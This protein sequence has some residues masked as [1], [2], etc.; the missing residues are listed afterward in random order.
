M[1]WEGTKDENLRE[2]SYVLDVYAF[3]GKIEFAGLF[4]LYIICSVLQSPRYQHIIL[5]FTAVLTAKTEDWNDDRNDNH[6]ANDDYNRNKRQ[7]CQ[8]R[9]SNNEIKK[10]ILTDIDTGNDNDIHL[11][12]DLFG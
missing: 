8:W 10:T 6:D 2:I 3:L 12:K 7:R 11:Q 4:S 1:K 5:L 9:T